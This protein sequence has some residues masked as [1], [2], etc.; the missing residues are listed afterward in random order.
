M[1]LILILLE[2]SGKF[3]VLR[4]YRVLSPAK[5]ILMF[6]YDFRVNASRVAGKI[7]VLMHFNESF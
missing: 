7:S 5:I 2:I 6:V 3:S 1:I 4:K